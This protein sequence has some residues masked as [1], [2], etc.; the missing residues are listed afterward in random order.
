MKQID[1]ALRMYEL[2]PGE[3][4][5]F[6]EY[7]DDGHTEA[8]KKGEGVTTQLHLSNNVGKAIF[9]VEPARGSFDGFVKEKETRIIFNVTR[10][11]KKVSAKINGKVQ[12]LT[13]A[14]SIEALDA[15]SNSF[16]YLSEVNL[17]RFATP[18]SEF[19]KQPLVKN[20]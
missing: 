14:G 1:A 2:Y 9:D 19:E 4:T 7:D 5:S 20:P 8:Y 11:P 15:M 10:K 3:K 12:K 18:G 6:V 17:N 13:E 16:L